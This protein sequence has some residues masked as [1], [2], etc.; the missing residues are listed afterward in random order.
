MLTI[1]PDEGA[2]YTVHNGRITSHQPGSIIDNA[3]FQWVKSP[4]IGHPAEYSL[5][6]TNGTLTTRPIAAVLHGEMWNDRILDDL[7][8]YVRPVTLMLV[9]S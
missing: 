7:H 8:H 5:T 1:I 3:L 4:I 6:G 2:P 9:D